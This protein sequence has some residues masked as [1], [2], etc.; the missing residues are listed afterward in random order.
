M[1]EPQEHLILFYFILFYPIAV[2]VFSGVQLFCD[3]MDC[4]LP[5]SSVHGIS[6]ARILEWVATSFS[7]GSFQSRGQTRGTYFS[8]IG[9]QILYHWCYL[10]SPLFY[11]ILVQT[12]K[13]S[14]AVQET[15]VRLLGWED[16]LEE[17]MATELE[18]PG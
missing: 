17:G 10:G 12:V 4:S 14:P 8:C 5:G 13:N 18:V 16:P 2:V 7:R 15:H 11:I 6:Q 3:P 1:N 9:R